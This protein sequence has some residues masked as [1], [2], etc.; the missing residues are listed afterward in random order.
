[1]T[2]FTRRRFLKTTAA[3]AGLYAAASA[4]SLR[5]F[6]QDKA[7]IRHFWWGNPDRD[8]RTFAAIDIFNKAHP[9][10][11]VVG[12]TLGFND[13]FTKLTTQIAGRNMPDVIQQGYGVMQEYV[14]R[15]AVLPLDD[16]VGK[17]LD[18]SKID[19][20]AID[21]GTFSGKF[22]GLSIGANS[23]VSMYNKRLFEAAKIEFDP[24][25]W[26]F[27]DLKALAVKIT[28]AN[29]GNVF[30]TD[31]NTADW[32]AF[33]NYAGEKGF[34]SQYEGKKLAFPQ[35]LVEE[36]WQVW[37]GMRD[38]KATP[39]GADSA[40]LVSPELNQL[41][42]VTG[43]TAISYA[44]SNQMVGTQALMKDKLGAAMRP[45]IAGGQPGQSIQPSQ[46]V[47]LSRDT[48]DADAAITYMNAF[49]NDPDMTMELGLERGIPSQSDVR[50]MLQ[51]T[52]TEI[53]AT[54]VEFFDAI[55]P[56]VAPLAPPNPPGALEVEQTFERLA[57]NVL[58]EQQSIADT[59][60][61]FMRQA[62]AVLARA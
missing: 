33:G 46:F 47:C 18:I 6:A 36:Y 62:E 35:S 27:D 1:M 49:V 52:L 11:E 17:G 58:L 48:V 7:R 28:E 14:D 10:I 45:H 53:E 41:G 16:Y 22:Y 60:S 21:A 2:P 37:K 32:G 39:P 23:Q 55:Q 15:G 26:T 56:Y 3:S 59:A 4:F 9:D 31:D 54:T 29:S 5:A 42:V 61:Q 8:K 25:K 24:I 12:E 13:Y 19:K 43:K 20:S 50:A 30:G 40:G 38:A 44:W 51:P 34:A 57:V